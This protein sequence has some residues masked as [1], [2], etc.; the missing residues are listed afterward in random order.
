MLLLTFCACSHMCA[1]MWA[2]QSACVRQRITRRIHF[3]HIFSKSYFIFYV[4]PPALLHSLSHSSMCMCMC[5][6]VWGGA[7]IQVLTEASSVQFLKLQLRAVMSTGTSHDKLNMNRSP[8]GSSSLPTI[9]NFQSR[10]KPSI[11]LMEAWASV[12]YHEA[13][14]G[15]R[16]DHN[17]RLPEHLPRTNLKLKPL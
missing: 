11:S 3:F 17:L 5:M 13:I 8:K 4:S 1:C 14:P 10:S 2:T 7:H 9:I 16:K 12:V 6:C 15:C